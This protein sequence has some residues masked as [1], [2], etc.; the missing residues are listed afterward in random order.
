[1]AA[2]LRIATLQG[3]VSRLAAEHKGSNAGTHRLYARR[4]HTHTH[5][6][7]HTHTHTHTHTQTHTHAHTHTHTHTP[8]T[9]SASFRAMMERASRVARE[10][11]LAKS[12]KSMVAVSGEVI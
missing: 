10:H 6:Q 11:V 5:T 3:E 8:H 9:D 1:M 12:H 7:T 2:E 4:A